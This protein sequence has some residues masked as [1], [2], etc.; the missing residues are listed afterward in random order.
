MTTEHAHEW[1]VN[2][3]GDGLRC[4]KCRKRLPFRYLTQEEFE[5]E[6]NPQTKEDGDLFDFKDVA[7]LP[8]R[9][10][11]TIIESG[12]V[13][14]DGNEDG[15][16]YADPGFHRINVLGYVTSETPWTDDIMVAVYFLDDFDRD[17][18]GD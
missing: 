12:G 9:N 5:K 11:W 15:N 7:N 10:V 3:K 8:T 14:D 16:W 4:V 18:E 2:A 17:D 1:V 6:F 13:D